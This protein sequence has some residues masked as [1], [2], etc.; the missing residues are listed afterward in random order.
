MY[1]LRILHSKAY[2]SRTTRSNHQSRIRSRFVIC[3]SI[4]FDLV[5]LLADRYE[6]STGKDVALYYAVLENQP[7][8]IW[9]LVRLGAGLSYQDG[10][11]LDLAVR[12]GYA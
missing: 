4:E 2:T 9:N 5:R 6:R 3:N 1:P 11:A 8:M 12:R 10:L 7:V